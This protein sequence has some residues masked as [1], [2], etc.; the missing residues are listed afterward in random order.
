VAG[1]EFCC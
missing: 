1:L